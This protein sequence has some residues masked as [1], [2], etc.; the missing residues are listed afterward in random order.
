MPIDLA[1]LRETKISAMRWAWFA[2]SRTQ[3][4]T[5]GRPLWCTVDGTRATSRSSPA[6]ARPASV[7]TVPSSPRIIHASSEGGAGVIAA[8]IDEFITLSVACPYWRDLLRE[9]SGGG[10]LD[11]MRRAQPR[12]KHHGWM[13]TR[14]TRAS[15]ELLMSEIGITPP[16]DVVGMLFATSR[17]PGG[18]CA[19][20][21][22][23]CARAAVR[24]LHHRPQSD[25]EAVHGLTP[26]HPQNVAEAC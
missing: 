12:W 14:T 23:Q 10:K 8:D 19:C 18:V 16:E 15:A 6:T 22:R 20:G 17:K 4:E 11:E 13:T 21:G 3:D 24:Q 7:V 9:F 5:A 2:T 25:A 1:K 26:I